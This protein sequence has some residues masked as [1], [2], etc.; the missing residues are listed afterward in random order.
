MVRSYRQQQQ[1]CFKVNGGEKCCILD[2]QV[3]P[4]A[5]ETIRAMC[6]K[7]MISISPSIIMYFK[8]IQHI[9]EDWRKR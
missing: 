5:L 4:P 8:Y 7:N 2:N 3:T 9:M 1:C 6:S